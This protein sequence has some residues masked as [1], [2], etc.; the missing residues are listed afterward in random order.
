MGIS[1]LIPLF[2]NSEIRSHVSE[3]ADKLRLMGL[4]LIN[5]DIVKVESK[6]LDTCFT[7][8]Y[9]YRSKEKVYPKELITNCTNEN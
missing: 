8:E 5:I 4:W 6:D 9:E 3:S 2:F 7:W 1:R